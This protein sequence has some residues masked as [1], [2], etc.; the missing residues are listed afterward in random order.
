MATK[1]NNLLISLASAVP[2]TIGSAFRRVLSFNVTET[3][4][5]T[6]TAADAFGRFLPQFA[7][8]SSTDP[9]NFRSQRKPKAWFQVMTPV[10]IT[11]GANSPG[12]ANVVLDWIAASGVATTAASINPVLTRNYRLRAVIN[13]AITSAEYA[14]ATV[15]GEVYVE[16]PHTLEA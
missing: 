1:S 10:G 15:N 3:T 13:R 14:R 11:I 5:G 8:A 4:I 2:N 16:I 7:A 6:T 12:G 9:A